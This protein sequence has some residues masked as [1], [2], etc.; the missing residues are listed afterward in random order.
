MTVWETPW[1]FLWGVMGWVAFG[2]VILGFII[3]LFAVLVGMFRGVAQ[4]V[5]PW[6]RRNLGQHR[7]E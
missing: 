6:K 3:L 2:L 5:K 4:L 7:A 1:D